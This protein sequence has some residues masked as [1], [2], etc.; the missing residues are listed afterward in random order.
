MFV[1]ERERLAAAVLTELDSDITTAAVL[2]GQIL[3]HFPSA[4]VH[5]DSGLLITICTVLGL[6]CW[7][8]GLVPL[9]FRI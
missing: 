8:Q 9:G 2:T 4:A 3:T 5:T 7:V 6:G 1:R